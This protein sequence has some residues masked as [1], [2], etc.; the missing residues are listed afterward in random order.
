MRGGVPKAT[1]ETVKYRKMSPRAWGCT[2][3]KEAPSETPV[4]VPTCVGVYRAGS[5]FNLSRRKCPHVRGGVPKLFR[6]AAELEKC[7][8]VRGGVPMTCWRRRSGHEMSPRAWG[9]TA[10]GWLPSGT[11]KNV[12]T[13]VGVYRRRRIYPEHTP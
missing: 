1:S 12:P 7:P 8:H 11:T 10:G 4:N 6:L 5:C 9:C 3:L 13:C 2:A